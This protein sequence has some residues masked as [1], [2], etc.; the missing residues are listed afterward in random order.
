M[1]RKRRKEPDEIIAELGIVLFSILGVVL[2]F[3]LI[4]L[5]FFDDKPYGSYTHMTDIYLDFS[6]NSHDKSVSSNE[7]VSDN[8]STLR[9]C[10]RCGHVLRPNGRCWWCDAN[11]SKC[12]EC[13]GT[14]RPSGACWNGC[15]EV[16]FTR[17][18][19][20]PPVVE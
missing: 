1:K 9:Q 5:L 12:D 4:R 10:D 2:I 8:T 15:D 14:L 6:N 11:N 3:C 13:G 18:P 20:I 16:R 17:M 19:F 7:S